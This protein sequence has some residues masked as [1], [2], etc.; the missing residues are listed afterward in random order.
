MVDAGRSKQKLLAEGG[1]LSKFEVHWI[2]K[3]AALQRT[4]RAGRV[5]PGH[6]YR[7]ARATVPCPGLQCMVQAPVGT[8]TSAPCHGSRTAGTLRPAARVV[9]YLGTLWAGADTTCV[10]GT[11]YSD[12]CVEAALPGQVQH[13]EPHWLLHIWTESCCWPAAVIWALATA[14]RP[15]GAAPAG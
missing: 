12:R 11:L 5:G 6:C 9:A 13:R 2:S 8:Q 4:G 3:A 7:C 15:T 10:V 1:G 14:K